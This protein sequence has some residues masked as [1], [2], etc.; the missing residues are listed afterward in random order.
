[1]TSMNWRLRGACRDEDP[2]LFFP[3]A[4]SGPAA[5]AQEN[6]AKAVCARCPVSSDCLSEALQM[7]QTHG[8]WGGASPAELRTMLR[9]KRFEQHGE[10]SS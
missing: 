5:V 7:G 6:A 8:V 3:V 1:M 9:R 4:I 2:E 10:V